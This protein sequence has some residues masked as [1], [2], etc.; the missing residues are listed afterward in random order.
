MTDSSNPKNALLTI[1]TERAPTAIGP[2]SQALATGPWVF[3]SGGLPLRADGTLVEGDIVAQ[4]RQAIANLK[5]ILEAAGA[6]LDTVLKTTVFV[7]N[8]DDFAQLNEAYA[9]CFGAHKPARST[10]EVARLPRDA[11]VEIEAIAL[12]TRA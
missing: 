12:R 10:V 4:T 3:V 5:A 9:N 1:S 8:L 2:Y 11:K 6:G 7:K